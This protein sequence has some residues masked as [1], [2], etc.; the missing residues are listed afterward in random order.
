[1]LCC[2]GEPKRVSVSRTN[3]GI[4]DSE[5]AARS[6]PAGGSCPKQFHKDHY[7]PFPGVPPLNKILPRPLR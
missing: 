7:F 1:M 3:G 2:S 5:A 6:A 4:I